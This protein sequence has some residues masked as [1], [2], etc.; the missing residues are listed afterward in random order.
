MP[1][2]E[3]AGPQK[4]PD[5]E[6]YKQN[7][8]KCEVVDPPRPQFKDFAAILVNLCVSGHTYGV[9]CFWS[10]LQRFCGGVAEPQR[11]YSR[12]FAVSKARHTFLQ[13][14]GVVMVIDTFRA[15]AGEP[16]GLFGILLG[17]PF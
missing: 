1:T 12:F 7:S 5:T 14:V 3:V 8:E 9:V 17:Y 11:E 2:V 13:K 4:P 10:C 16:F 6:K 15:L